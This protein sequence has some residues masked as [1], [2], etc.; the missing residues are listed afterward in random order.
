M[1]TYNILLF[2][3]MVFTFSCAKGPNIDDQRTKRSPM[4]IYTSGS[5]GA[6]NFMLIKA[7]SSFYNCSQGQ[8]PSLDI[9]CSLNDFQTVDGKKFSLNQLT[10]DVFESDAGDGI[11]V[12]AYQFEDTNQVQILIASFG[13]TNTIN[14][15]N[16]QQ[17]IFKQE[18]YIPLTICATN[19]IAFN[20][21][22]A[23]DL[24]AQQDLKLT[25]DAD[26]NNT[27]GIAIIVS[28]SAPEFS[29]DPAY[30]KLVD[31]NG[32]YTIPY[33]D[34]ATYK[35]MSEPTTTLIRANE[36]IITVD[37]KKVSLAAFSRCS[38]MLNF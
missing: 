20:E 23:Y 8:V 37:G 6:E 17:D 24:T 22:Y 28:N 7:Y 3:L 36:I 1:R 18:L 21:D 10:L 26:A 19:E 14:M 33:A 9:S 11:G 5:L 16:Q 4:E 25:W 30:I 15:F 35:S 29:D 13:K 27:N 12:N 34:I 2:S 31:D 32:S 38:F